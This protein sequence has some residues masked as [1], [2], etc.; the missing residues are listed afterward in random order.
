VPVGARS[1][2]GIL[3]PGKRGKNTEIDHEGHGR[4]SFVDNKD[5]RYYELFTPGDSHDYKWKHQTHEFE[6][7]KEDRQLVDEKDL[8]KLKNAYSSLYNQKS[9][10]DPDLLK[11][12]LLNA[13]IGMT[14][15]F[16][17]LNSGNPR[18]IHDEIDASNVINIKLTSLPSTLNKNSFS[19]YLYGTG[20]YTRID[21]PH[22]VD[23]YLLG[24]NTSFTKATYNKTFEFQTKVFIKDILF[25]SRKVFA[26]TFTNNCWVQFY[27]MNNLYPVKS[28]KMKNTISTMVNG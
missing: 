20:E 21:I 7:Y 4:A 27:A 10:I 16:A 18:H 12:Y 22:N 23:H 25:V 2:G 8:L 24:I 3:S 6:R 15:D 11:D 9:N 26:V 17:N 1:D 28:H 14:G 13:R 19:K 5:E